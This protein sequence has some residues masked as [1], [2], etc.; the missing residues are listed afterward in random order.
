MSFVRFVRCITY[1]VLAVAGLVQCV[2]AADAAGEKIVVQVS[3]GDTKT[4]NQALNVIRNLKQA[5]GRDTQVQLVVFGNGIGMLQMESEVGQRV[6]ETARAGTQVSA[7]E[8]T[9]QGRKLR[10][11]DMLADIAY[12]PSG[13]VEIIQKQRQG[14]AVLRP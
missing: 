4:W 5:Y 3:D 12:V 1:V 10:K 13:V 7:C 2:H 6:H 14:W 8:N 11:D 9:M